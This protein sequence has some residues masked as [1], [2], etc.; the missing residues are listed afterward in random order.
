MNTATSPRRSAAR[1]FTLVELITS[2]TLF[3]ILAVML[4]QTV[5]SATDVWSR[6]E[7]NRE[8]HERAEAVFALLGE[9]LRHAWSGLRGAGEQ[10]ARFLCERAFIGGDVDGE[11]PRPVTALRFTR[12]L[13]EGRRLDALRTAG[14]AVGGSHA[15]SLLPGEDPADWLPTGGLAES[16]FTLARRAGRDDWT[17]MRRVR[18]RAGGAGS[19]VA[20]EAL[21]QVDRLLADAVP[22]AEG[23]L[24]F[25]LAFDDPRAGAAS[26]FTEKL[27]TWDSTRGLTGTGFALNVDESS[28]W[29]GHDD[30]LPK[31]VHVELVLEDG[32]SVGRL[33]DF[34]DGSSQR[35]TVS[36]DA[37][38]EDVRY[39]LVGDEW[40]ELIET[41][42][43][44]VG[45]DGAGGGADGGRAGGGGPGGGGPDG[46][47]TAGRTVRV[48]RG[49]R[50]TS[51]RAHE[52][53]AVLRAGRSFELT[54]AIPAARERLQW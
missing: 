19:L 16:L 24:H 2:M 8:L 13:H 22:I 49:A 32:E 15:A 6:G 21:E 23:V 7:R 40:M 46:G 17:L 18:A 33:A 20:A 41:A 42:T 12:L 4:F 26:A 50:G 10:E 47:G 30:V 3:T 27:T 44:G 39:V 52:T 38:L 5:T 28:V 53:G 54:V 34:I 48:R 31:L 9:D 43:S 29:S 11:E 51:K 37:R 1:G 45:G 14:D 36:R 35:L 25:G